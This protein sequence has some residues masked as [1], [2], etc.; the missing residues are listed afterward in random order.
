MSDRS[1]TPV[2]CSFYDKLEELATLRKESLIK[3]REED[4]DTSET[5]GV[6]K[7]FFIREGVEYLVTDKGAEVRLDNIVTVNGEKVENLSS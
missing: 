1:Y 4:G 5:L 3:Y 6:I 2:N 7:D